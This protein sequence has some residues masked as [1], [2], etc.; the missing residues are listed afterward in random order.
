MVQNQTD[1]PLTV[2]VAVARRATSR[3][4]TA[5]GRRL[6][7]PAN[8][9]VEVR[10]PGR[11][12]ARARRGFQVG[13]A[14]RHLRRRRARSSCRSRRRRPP[15]PSPPTA[16]STRAPSSS[17]SPR[18]RA[19]SRVRRARDHDL[20]DR[21]PGARPTPCSTWSPTRSSAR[22]SSRRAS[23]RSPRCKDVL[24]AFKAEGL[25]PPEELQ[26][27]V[28]R[29]VERLRAL[30]N[31]DG[32]FGFWRRGERVVAVRLASTSRTR[33]QRAKAK[34]FSVPDG[35]AASARAATCAR[36]SSTSRRT[37]ARSRAARSSAYALYVRR[38]AG[39]RDPAQARGAGRRGAASRSCRSRPSAGCCRS[40][41]TG[42]GLAGRGSTASG[43][44]IANRVSETAGAAHFTARTATTPTCCSTPTAA[45]TP[46]CSR[47]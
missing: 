7:V 31:D 11:R 29:D 20:V 35:D 14:S 34:G 46:S 15:R 47:R 32:G 45:P 22:S 4:R 43:A 21:A 38:A 18:P 17:R 23:W 44:R 19:A 37:T 41:S 6:V 13:A 2:D 36:S 30:Q 27:A 8:D 10:F 40:L 39:R 1:A 16:R 3:S 25:P 26:R 5:P 42:R 24:T 28:E 33:S 9:R 12:A